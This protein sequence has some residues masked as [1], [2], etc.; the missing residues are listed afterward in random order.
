MK[1]VLSIFSLAISLSFLTGCG[2]GPAAPNAGNVQGAGLAD[3]L[4]DVGNDL[5][6]EVATNDQGTGAMFPPMTVTDVP[7]PILPAAQKQIYFR[8]L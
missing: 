4:K 3:T 8:K 6:G 1:R 5:G 2:G 7:N